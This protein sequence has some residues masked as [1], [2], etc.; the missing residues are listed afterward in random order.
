MGDLG[1]AGASKCLESPRGWRWGARPLKRAED[2]ACALA[3]PVDWPMGPLWRDGRVELA[4]SAFCGWMGD[5]GWE[6]REM[7]P[8]GC[9]WMKVVGAE[10]GAPSSFDVRSLWMELHRWGAKIEAERLDAECAQGEG[11]KGGK[12]GGRL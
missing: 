2:L 8:A 7:G 5:R 9:M 10:F 11:G 1:Q 4:S 12:G 6:I 3:D